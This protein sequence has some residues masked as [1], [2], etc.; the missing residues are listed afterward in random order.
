MFT[1]VLYGQI[2]YHHGKLVGYVV[3]QQDKPKNKQIDTSHHAHA[4]YTMHINRMHKAT[5]TLVLCVWVCASVN[6]T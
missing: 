5:Y 2:L 6:Y 4:G 1:L 3:S